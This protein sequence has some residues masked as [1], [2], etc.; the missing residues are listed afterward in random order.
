MG[1]ALKRNWLGLRRAPSLLLMPPIRDLPPVDAATGVALPRAP[2]ALSDTELTFANHAA[3][4]V[5]AQNETEDRAAEKAPAKRISARR[6]ALAESATARR[7]V[8]EHIAALD[9]TARALQAELPLEANTL[10]AP[11]LH[12]MD[13]ALAA[14]LNTLRKFSEHARR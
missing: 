7:K 1:Q 2:S 3:A 11:P 12:D 8:A 10:V 9:E 5:K 13:A 4:K 14:A 6:Q